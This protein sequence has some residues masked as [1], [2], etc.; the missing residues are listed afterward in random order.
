[1][2]QVF[3]IE[4]M[5][6]GGCVASVERAVR[7]LNGIETVQVDLAD[8]SARIRFDPALTTPAQVKE[9]IEDAGYDVVG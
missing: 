3:R 8:K 6:C 2:E 5:S 4:G 7:T 9:A 1:M